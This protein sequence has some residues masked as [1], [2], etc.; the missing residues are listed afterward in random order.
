[1]QQPLQFRVLK[2]ELQVP[3]A[4][5]GKGIAASPQVLLDA[6]S[7]QQYQSG[8]YLSLPGISRQVAP[9]F[10]DDRDGITAARQRDVQM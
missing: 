3:S 7:V 5:D 1:M 8:A 10:L 9:G 6:V 2:D 4:R